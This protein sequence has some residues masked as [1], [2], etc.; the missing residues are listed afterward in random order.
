MNID[1]LDLEKENQFQD[2]PDLFSAVHEDDVQELRAALKSVPHWGGSPLDQTRPAFDEMTP[3]HLA[4]VRGSRKVFDEMI[5]YA[6]PFDPF[7]EDGLGRMA[8]DYAL[9]FR[10]DDIARALQARIYPDGWASSP[11]KKVAPAGT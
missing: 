7:M 3:V 8:I 5:S 1:W 6:K 9:A 4:C 11:K 10:R 2:Y